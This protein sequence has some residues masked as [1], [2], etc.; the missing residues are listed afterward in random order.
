MTWKYNVGFVI[1]ACILTAHPALAQQRGAAIASE[2]CASCHG[3]K[4]NSPSSAF[5]NLASQQKDYLAAQLKAFR[6]HTRADP[7]AQ[8]FMWGM[9]SQLT[10][11]AIG[12]LA[13]Y[14]ASQKATPEKRPDAKLAKQGRDIF[15]HGIPDEKVPACITCHGARAEGNGPMPRLADQHPEYLLKQLALFKTQVR[16]GANSPQMHAVTGGMTFDQMAAVAAYISRP[17]QLK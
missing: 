10:D 15:E 1:L 8:A 7:M 16:A 9:A 17:E 6:D 2:V 14:Y 3:P 5:P 11:E 4:G 12:E 13:A